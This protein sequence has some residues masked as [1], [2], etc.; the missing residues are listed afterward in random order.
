MITPYSHWVDTYATTCTTIPTTISMRDS[1]FPKF[2]TTPKKEAIPSS[3]IIA[4]KCTHSLFSEPLLFAN[5][6]HLPPFFK[7]M[8]FSRTA[9]TINSD[10]F[11][12]PRSGLSRI[13]SSTFFRR[14]SG[15]LTVV[16][17]V[18]IRSLTF[19]S[20]IT[21]WSNVVVLYGN[22]LIGGRY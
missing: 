7:L 22:S 20:K 21:V 4:A 8:S 3:Q 19:I 14:G 12:Y 6:Y 11:L 18:A 10:R 1:I 2:K 17:R 9:S 16:Y 13:K 5:K 15:I